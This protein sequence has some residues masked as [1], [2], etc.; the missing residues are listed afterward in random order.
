[1]SN[2]IVAVLI[3]GV[4]KNLRPYYGDQDRISQDCVLSFLKISF[5]LLD[6]Y[7]VS[8]ASINVVLDTFGMWIP[9]SG[10][11]Q[12]KSTLMTTA[13]KCEI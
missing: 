6:R 3:S 12:M 8:L 1:M 2:R 9:F 13:K 7:V 4:Q 11:T 10:K 5:F